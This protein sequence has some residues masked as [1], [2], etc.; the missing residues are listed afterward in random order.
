MTEQL[1]IFGAE[2]EKARRSVEQQFEIFWTS[3]P[4]KKGKE[5]A[6][7]AF[8]IAIK[9][10]SL[11]KMLDAIT[12]YVANKPDWQKY[13]HP[14]PWLRGGHYLDEWEPPQAKAPPQAITT[15]HLQRYQTR[16]EYLAAER[17]RAERSFR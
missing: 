10:T 16:E 9:K 8:R 6:L 1:D 11:E 14:G 5:D 17:A 4:N 15:N 12:L 3:Y 13:K 7:K 2:I